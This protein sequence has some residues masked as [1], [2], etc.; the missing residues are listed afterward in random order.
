MFLGSVSTWVTRGFPLWSTLCA[1]LALYYPP[2]FLWYGPDAIGWGLGLIMLGMGMTLRPSDFLEVWRAPK[3]IA[4]GVGLQF[5]VMPA[6]S[7]FLAWVMQLPLE[8]SVGLI[9]VACCP[10]G[11][12]SNVVVFLAKARTAL[13]VSI[14]LCSTFVAVVL[15]PW[16]TFVYAGHY[17][18]IDPW[19]LFRSILMV[20]LI[21]LL[22]GVAWNQWSPKTAE[23]VAQFSPM[24]SVV[25]ILLIVGFVLAAKQD[26]ILTHGWVLLGA[27]GLLHAGGFAGGYSGARLLGRDRLDQQTI[28]IEV[29]MQNSGLGTALATK[30]FANMPMTPAPCALSAI[31]HC[32]MGSFLASRWRRANEKMQR[33]LNKK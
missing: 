29:G 24:V 30:H 13:S 22:I 12:A 4:L 2:F 32:L 19:A 25:F 17:L 14:T 11:T 33:D 8:M 31:L 18:P 23:K 15:T 7:A 28:S 1:C 3:V 21:P 20:V 16:L 9:L 27:T 26:L 10:G 6:W 5:L